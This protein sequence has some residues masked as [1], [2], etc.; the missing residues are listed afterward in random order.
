MLS[1]EVVQFMYK[2]TSIQIHSVKRYNFFYYIQRGMVQE[3]EVRSV[4]HWV[5]PRKYDNLRTISPITCAPL[6]PNRGPVCDVLY[7]K[8]GGLL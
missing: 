5:K 6:Y 4:S 2:N 7:R 8:Y 1:Y 3:I